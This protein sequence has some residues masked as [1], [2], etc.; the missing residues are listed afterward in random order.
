MT[1]RRATQKRR[2]SL[3]RLRLSVPA[4]LAVGAVLVTASTLGSHQYTLQDPAATDASDSA[5]KQDE[6]SPDQQV[7]AA[8]AVTPSVL[9]IGD[10]Y[11]S[12]EVLDD[13]DQRFTTL[14]SNELGWQEDNVALGGTGYFTQVVDDDGDVRP[15]YTNVLDELPADL[16]PDAIMVT[17]GGNDTGSDLSTVTQAALI[18]DFFSSLRERFPH[19]P[20]YVVSPFWNASAEPADLPNIR[21]DVRRSAL[22]AGATYLDIGHPLEN[23]P[24]LVLDDG[25]HPNDWGNEVIA[26]DILAA[27]QQ[28][29]GEDLA[30]LASGTSV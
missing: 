24:E 20:V 11:T 5:Q 6:Q 17:G 30:E 10:S 22:E 3:T 21:D 25:D 18:D 28:A 7:A 12:G 23:H 29:T 4:A 27:M 2:R 26:D 19:T 15:D 14:I 9:F 13:P 1:T 16:T 8:D